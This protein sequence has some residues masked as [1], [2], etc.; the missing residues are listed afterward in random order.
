MAHW[1]P[2]ATVAIEDRRF[3]QHGALDYTG[4]ARAALKDLESGRAE[5]GAS[6]LTQ[7]LARN[8]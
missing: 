4:I 7:Q 8:L 2:A 3:W 6:T 5:Q 1:L